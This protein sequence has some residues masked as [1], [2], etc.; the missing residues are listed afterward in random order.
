M[1]IKTSIIHAIQN[2]DI[3]K[4][5]PLLDK[6]VYYG[7]AKENFLEEFEWAF[8]IFKQEGDTQLL[9]HEGTCH[10]KSFWVDGSRGYSF[11]G[12]NSDTYLDII[13]EG[14]ENNVTDIH[15]CDY[16]KTDDPAI[17]RFSRIA[18]FQSDE[19]YDCEHKHD[20]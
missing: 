15:Y 8:G 12:N 11:V 18:L 4:L 2:M 10:C 13:I 5:R 14:D 1:D 17:D 16:F 9:V 20:D 6:E 19:K 3:D 7:V